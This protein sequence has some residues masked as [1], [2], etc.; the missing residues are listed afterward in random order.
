[1]LRSPAQVNASVTWANL[2]GKPAAF[3]STA[4]GHAWGEIT[5]KPA[6]YPPTAHTHLWADLTDKP[7]TFAPAAHSHAWAE[8]TGKPTT[9]APATHT[10]SYN[11]LTDKPTIP[12]GNTLIGT[13]TITETASIA[14]LAGTR[15]VTVS[16]PGAVVGG[17]YAL[18]PVGATPAG[19]AI[20]D[21]VATAA[22]VLQV[23]MIVP[24]IVLG[25][26]YSLPC[27][28]VRINT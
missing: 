17:N 28:L 23:T 2:P 21:V 14:I 24:A 9:F 11:E 6:A 12:A 20:A 5:G 18:F 16:A 25:G 10:H 7:A 13:V 3:A 4:H 27:R 19:Y 1:M 8:I 15:K 22:N 26:S